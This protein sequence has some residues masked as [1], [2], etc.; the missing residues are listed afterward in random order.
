M[1]NENKKMLESVICLV[2]LLVLNIITT[3]LI[4]FNIEWYITCVFVLS[5][6][7]IMSILTFHERK[8][9][10]YISFINKKM[11][12][13]QKHM[14]KNG[15]VSILYKTL[16][17][18]CLP[19]MRSYLPKKIY[20]YYTLNDNEGFNLKRINSLNE[21]CVF[22]LIASSFNDPFEGKYV[23]LTEE[24]LSQLGAPIE[25]KQI[26]ETVI[27]AISEH[28]TTICF[29]Q[30]PNNMP[31]WAHYA[32][33]HQGFCVEYEIINDY[34]FYPV[35]YVDNRLKFISL[36]IELFY[37]LL[38]EKATNEDKHI[39]LRYIMF[40]N[41]FKDSSWKSEN[42][43]RA[44]FLNT[45]QELNA[46]GKLYTF[47]E[48]GIKPTKLFI[49]TCCSDKNKEELMSVAKSLSIEYEQ[50]FMKENEKFSVIS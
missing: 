50:C 3:I 20:K 25:A 44:V 17:E 43:I 32:N 16:D 11:K 18:E 46:N 33:E 29:T 49:G 4:L 42:E 13:A 15:D 34:N 47:D 2:I 41:S 8:T 14:R 39:V 1:R 48:I 22:G 12:K 35:I 30:N 31:M 5:S 19:L 26:L 37:A 24:D 23:F 7:I 10:T 28:I 9:N 36:F 45:K 27:S 21:K 38:D 6:I 40:L